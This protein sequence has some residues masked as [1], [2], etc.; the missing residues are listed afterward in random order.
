MHEHRD[1]DTGGSGVC[2]HSCRVLSALSGLV[3]VELE[4]GA[5][6]GV[7]RMGC[8]VPVSSEWSKR[9]ECA[10]IFQPRP[11]YFAI[12]NTKNSDA[13][14]IFSVC[15]FVCRYVYFTSSMCV[16]SFLATRSLFS[17]SDIYT[18]TYTVRYQI[19]IIIFNIQ[20]TPYT[21]SGL[22]ALIDSWH[23]PIV[24][25]PTVCLRDFLRRFYIWSRSMFLRAILRIGST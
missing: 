23:F 21:P 16:C 2:Q 10:A 18:L 8:A 1:Q 13:G 17:D 11:T 24:V 3:A 20:I 15:F 9:F 4:S 7:L 6:T 12:L 22:G 19:K 14:N 25:S 5:H